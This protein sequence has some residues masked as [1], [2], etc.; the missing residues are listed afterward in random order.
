MRSL[1]P[2]MVAAL[3]LTGMA[4]A[5]APPPQWLPQESWPG[6]RRY[7]A[8]LE[9]MVTFWG[10]GVPAA[11]VFASITKQTGVALGFDPPDD[12][13]ARICLNVY[14]NPKE[15]P[16]LRD[17]LV[18]IGWVLDCAWAVE[19]EGEQSRYVLLHTDIGN[20][21]LQ[22]LGKESMQ[23]AM[24]R[25]RQSAEAMT[26]AEEIALAKL[27][28]IGRSLDLSRD[29]IIRRYK[30][31]DN[32]MLLALLDPGKRA[33][34]QFCL[35]LD[36]D[37]LRRNHGAS[38][39]WRDLSAEQQHLLRQALEPE[40]R[41]TAE[42]MRWGGL[43]PES[44]RALGWSTTDRWDNWDWVEREVLGDLSLGLDYGFL[45]NSS[46]GPEGYEPVPGHPGAFRL[47][48]P[49][50]PQLPAVWLR[51]HRDP[52]DEASMQPNIDDDLERLLGERVPGEPSTEFGEVHPA[53]IRY[54]EER[55][56][57]LA[58]KQLAEQIHL[59]PSAAERLSSLRL[60]A[61]LDKP[62]ALWQLQE[63]VA[64][65]SGMHVISD[66]LWQPARTAKQIL[67][68][69]HRDQP[70][71]PNALTLLEMT[72]VA[73]E[74]RERL[75]YGTINKTTQLTRWEWGDAGEFLRFRSADRDVWRAAFLPAG[76]VDTLHDWLAPCLPE[77]LAQA[78]Q[79]AVPLDVR[80]CGALMKQL[81]YLQ[82]RWGGTL[83]YGRPTVE[84]E[85]WR[86]SFRHQA[87]TVMQAGGRLYVWLS[88]LD[89]D[90]WKRLQAEG[91]RVGVDFTIEPDP[92][93][94]F[95][96]ES[97]LASGTALRLEPATGL[98]R[99][100]FPTWQ[101]GSDWCCLEEL[102]APGTRV[103]QPTRHP[104]AT[105]VTVRPERLPHLV[106]PAE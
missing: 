85:R 47:G 64:A 96:W 12:D 18:Q 82:R 49:G 90:Q 35:T 26:E 88:V 91:L 27:Q 30:G 62:Y 94:K 15:P 67:D 69:L 84:A 60:P 1:L 53:L 59:S 29:E 83:S 25:G 7:D 36:Q 3:L 6:G 57:A 76:V 22:D 51:L 86:W 39:K 20:N 95:R 72:T 101:P 81:N 79:V 13:N 58:E 19:G 10:T 56:R 99:D 48:P 34:A 54:R 52:R 75:L 98:E 24:A 55:Q 21:V 105:Q 14:L 103:S 46:R 63:A 100:Q 80:R 44:M 28:E 68:L 11:D 32:L 37:Q 33:M 42:T 4:H 8:R 65:L 17:L 2:I 78:K 9:R 38:F 45:L 23:E 92:E 71:E 50:H 89:D 31:K 66:S 77:D 5:A 43:H 87:M 41:E 61:A 102:L 70:C 104:L 93:D 74:T 16:T 73:T 40:L 106:P 97:E